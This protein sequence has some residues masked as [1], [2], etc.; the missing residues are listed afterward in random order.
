MTLDQIDAL[1]KNVGCVSADNRCIQ[2]FLK[3]KYYT[4]LMDTNVTPHELKQNL[5]FLK[6]QLCKTDFRDKLIAPI[7]LILK[8]IL[9]LDETKKSKHRG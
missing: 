2:E 6:D 9:L 8:K 3:R 7:R 5:I 4:I 1:Q